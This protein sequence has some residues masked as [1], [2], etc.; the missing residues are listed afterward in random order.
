[1]FL[2]YCFFQTIRTDSKLPVDG[3][4]KPK[5]GELERSRFLINDVDFLV[6][7]ST[8]LGNLSYRHG[9]TG[10]WYLDALYQNLKDNHSK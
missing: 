8:L 2:C 6:G 5:P 9:Q 7:Y 4:N 1:M 3:N 10:S